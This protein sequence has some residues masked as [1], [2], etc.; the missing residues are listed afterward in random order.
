VLGRRDLPLLSGWR[1][2]LAGEEL[3]ALL[4]ARG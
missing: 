3:L 4:E 1:R 2:E